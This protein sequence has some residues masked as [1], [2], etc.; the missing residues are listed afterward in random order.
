M[1]KERRRHS[2]SCTK[3][4]VY[5]EK[6]RRSQSCRRIDYRETTVYKERIPGDK[7]EALTK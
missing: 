6:T 7:I 1:Y 3:T 2:Q 5:K 4:I